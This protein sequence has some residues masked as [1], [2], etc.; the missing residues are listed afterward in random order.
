MKNGRAQKL[1]TKFYRLYNVIYTMRT[2]IIL[3]ALSV[4]CMHSFGQGNYYLSG[5]KKR[6][7]FPDLFEYRKSGFHFA[8]GLTR[9]F[10]IPGEESITM[11][12]GN[13]LNLDPKGKLKF[14]AEV[15]MFHILE[16]GTIIK[17][18]DW[19]VAWK[20]TQGVENYNIN[21]GPNSSGSWSDN[22]VSAFINFN[23][24]ID[25]GAV[26]LQNTLGA[27]FDYVFSRNITASSGF[28]DTLPGKFL[29]QIHYK[30]G[31]GFRAT[32]KLLCIPTLEVPLVNFMPFWKPNMT[33]FN[34]DYLPVIFTLRFML[35]RPKKDE[36]PPVYA[37][38]MMK[39]MAPDGVT[40]Q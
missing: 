23:N 34:S 28:N 7:A 18:W 13:Q 31:F 4:L 27:N 8:P 22:N 5:N 2:P 19:G 15:G 30:L 16:Y 26:F 20:W 40:P 17:Y 6:S 10:P 12:D 24:K 25:L 3:L 9:T 14:Y 35:I 32:K 29:P 1:K 33:Y 39:D 11:D 38:G 36:C 21:G 37:P